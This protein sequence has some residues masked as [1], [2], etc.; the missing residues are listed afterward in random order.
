[1]Q[2]EHNHSQA[3]EP[4]NPVIDVRARSYPSESGAPDEPEQGGLLDYWR[5]INRRKGTVLLIAFFGLLIGVLV[6]LPQTPVYQ[7][8]TSL[9]IQDINQ[10]FLNVKEVSPVTD[11]GSYA[12]LTDIQTQIK[13]LQSDTLIERTAQKLRAAGPDALGSPTGRIPSWRR[14]LN[15]PEPTLLSERESTLRAAASNL[16][17][18]AAGQTRIIE[19]LFDSTN[20]K[21]AA[22]FLNTNRKS[23]RLNSSHLGISYAVFCL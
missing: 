16:K 1:M 11:S 18:R 13:I 2:D 23:T 19:I 15:L 6:T 7:A 3:L 21:L 10:N 9:E 22:D 5:I 12:A 20:P 8:R 14:A 4:R 17:V